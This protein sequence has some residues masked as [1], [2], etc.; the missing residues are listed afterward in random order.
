MMPSYQTRPPGAS[1]GISAAS[2]N[3]SSPSRKNSPSLRVTD[4]STFSY[5]AATVLA[6]AAS[7]TSQCGA[8]GSR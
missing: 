2:K 7:S 8:P 4:R 5:L 6:S 1:H 3:R